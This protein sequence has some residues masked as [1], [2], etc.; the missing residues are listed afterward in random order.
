M[1]VIRHCPNDAKVTLAL[2]ALSA[3]GILGWLATSGI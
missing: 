2:I 3:V 1:P